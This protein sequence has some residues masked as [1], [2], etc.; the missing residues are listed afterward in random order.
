[1][2]SPFIAEIKM[3]GYNFAPRGYAFC[4]GQILPIAQNTA[5]FA[6]VGTTYGGNGTT[7]FGL[8]DLQ[9]RSPLGP[10]QGPG[11]STYVL[12]QASG[13][14]T[15]TLLST[16]MPAHTHLPQGNSTG[17]DST[18]PASKIW[19][20]NAATRSPQPLYSVGTPN[21]GMNAS[22]IA[23]AGGNSPHQNQQPYLAISFIIALQ[24]VFPARN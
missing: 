11:L 21:T 9:G 19:A 1:M 5:L 16:E 14:P 15:V 18:T 3:C 10:G 6:L 23:S 2:S 4:N 17:G 7:T 22:A 8:P 20:A 12:G 24:G 13:T